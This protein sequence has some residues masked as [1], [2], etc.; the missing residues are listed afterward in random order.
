MIENFQFSAVC[1]ASRQAAGHFS[2]PPPHPPQSALLYQVGNSIPGTG[3]MRTR[4]YC[5]ALLLPCIGV[6]I[7]QAYRRNGPTMFVAGGVCVPGMFLYVGTV[8]H[9]V[10]A[11]IQQTEQ[12]LFFGFPGKRIA[13]RAWSA[14]YL[15][16][17]GVHVWLFS[18]ALPFPVRL[19]EKREKITPVLWD[20]FIY[21]F[22]LFTSFSGHR[23]A[24]RECARRGLIGPMQSA[25]PTQSHNP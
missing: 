11:T 24:Q 21:L 23:P 13:K 25:I 12:V 19:P 1:L 6:R 20:R 17:S 15:P 3:D 10:Q 2:P 9:A 18:L 8:Y 5:F 14:R 22:Y 4:P 7:A 16:P